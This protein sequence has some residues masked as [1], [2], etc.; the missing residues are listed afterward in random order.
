MTLSFQRLLFANYTSSLLAVNTTILAVAAVAGLVGAAVL[1]AL[2]YLANISQSSGYS[3][4][5]YQY[6]RNRRSE[7]GMFII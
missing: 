7:E 5:N 3:Y 4:G 2:H 1:V 6:N